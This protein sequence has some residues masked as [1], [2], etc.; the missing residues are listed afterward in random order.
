MG[1]AIL[2]QLFVIAPISFW[3]TGGV[4]YVVTSLIKKAIIFP[5]ELVLYP[6]LTISTFRILYLLLLKIPNNKETV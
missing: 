2:L 6:F 1:I 5:V 3:S 4:G